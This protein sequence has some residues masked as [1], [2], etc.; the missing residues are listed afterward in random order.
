MVVIVVVIFDGGVAGRRVRGGNVVGG[1]GGDG[2]KA[3]N[4]GDKSGG[5]VGDGCCRC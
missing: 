3:G 5:G 4:R 2:G 1:S